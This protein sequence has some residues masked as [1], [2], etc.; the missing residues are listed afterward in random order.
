[1]KFVE[2]FEVVVKKIHMNYKIYS[3]T[4]NFVLYM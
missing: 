3:K 2:T 4:S 1:M